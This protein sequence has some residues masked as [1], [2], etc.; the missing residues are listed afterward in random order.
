M[1]RARCIV[2]D[3]PCLVVGKSTVPVGT[4]RRLAA[5]LASA[6]EGVELAWNPEFLRESTAVADTLSPDRVVAGGTSPRGDGNLPG[7]V[8]RPPPDGAA[9]ILA[10]LGTT[11]QA[12]NTAPTP[13][14]PQN[15]IFQT[16]G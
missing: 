10:H 12:E 6:C 3:R 9:F 4:A 16:R 11:A 1:K 7:G 8:P 2:L 15:P 14:P 5:E 13:P